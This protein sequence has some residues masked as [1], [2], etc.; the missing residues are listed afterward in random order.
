MSSQGRFEIFMT[1]MIASSDENVLSKMS[2][3]LGV[4][5]AHTGDVYGS[6]SSNGEGFWSESAEAFWIAWFDISIAY[7]GV[8]LLV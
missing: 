6:Y 4:L 7:N 5:I 8:L 1:S 2:W 3:L